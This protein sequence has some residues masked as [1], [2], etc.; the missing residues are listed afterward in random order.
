MVRRADG[1]AG[2]ERPANACVV[3]KINPFAAELADPKTDAE[4]RLIALKFLLHFIGGP[5]LAASLGRQ[6]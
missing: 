6:W 3:D 2:V 1:K 5:A 4:E